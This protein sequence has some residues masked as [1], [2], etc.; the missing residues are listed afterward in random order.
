MS[1]MTS[2]LS[3]LP[4]SPA[5]QK[6]LDTAVIGHVIEG[7]VVPSLSEETMAIIN[8][9]T[10]EEIGRAARGGPDEVERAVRS[11]R[12]AFDDGRWRNLAPLDKERRLRRL[13]ELVS[14]YGEVFSDIDVLDAGLLKVY[15]GFIV[16][17]A[18][19]ALD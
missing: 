2:D 5:G 11:A 10:G 15:T 3:D 9:A 17:F 8:P 18:V 12:A 6:Y 19:A 1:T 7:E 13:S 14:S 4:L 16:Q